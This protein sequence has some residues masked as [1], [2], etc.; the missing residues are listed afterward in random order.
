MRR[1]TR[2]RERA[3]AERFLIQEIERRDKIIS[4]STLG[5]PGASPIMAIIEL[6][7]YYLEELRSTNDLVILYL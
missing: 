2:T 6:C 5:V 1:S 4:R 3:E 7:E